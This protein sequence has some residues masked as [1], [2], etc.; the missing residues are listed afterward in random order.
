MDIKFSK[1]SKEAEDTAQP[2]EKG[3]QTGLLVLLLV[4]LG[5]F[6]Y[7]YFFTDLIRTQQ[8]QPAPQQLPQVVK[9]PLP[10]RSV[11]PADAARPVEPG[12]Q[13]ASPGTPPPSAVTQAAPVVA[14]LQ[15]PV[16]TKVVPVPVVKPEEKKP[17]AAKPV[18]QP[19]AIKAATT[20]SVKKL[21]PSQVV[22]QAVKKAEPTKASVSVAK[23]GQKKAE[24]SKAADKKVV[25]AKASSPQ[26]N[27]T[28]VSASKAGGPWTVVVGLYV[29][30]ETLAADL[31]EVKR[32]GLTPVMTSGPRRQ[33]TMNRLFLGDYAAKQ[34]AQQ[35]IEKLRS[36][37]GS[38]FILQQ[39]DKYEVYAGSYAVLS[40]AQTEQQRLAAAGV[41]VVVRKTQV[42]LASRKLTAGTY[43][44][45]KAA[46]AALKKLKNAGIGT[47]E[48]E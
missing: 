7:L 19:E 24:P 30:E 1:E 47:P 28:K 21:E 42:P 44:D 46:E 32:V 29:V 17:V 18:V 13:V 14:P 23:A 15:K 45:R 35:A 6:G 26:K 41:K 33:V 10:D 5:G 22:A 11:Q 40:G 3:R 2:Q 36:T 48:L 20:P 38:G 4:L 37:G 43:T 16:D 31:S 8:L 25:S 39:G 9:Q 34:D 12:A 27:V